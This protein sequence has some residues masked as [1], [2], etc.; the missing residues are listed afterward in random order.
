MRNENVKSSVSE[1]LKL[2]AKS[3]V[4][5]NLATVAT[6]AIFSALMWRGD[7]PES[8]QSDLVLASVFAGGIT[9]GLV[10]CK[11][12]RRGLAIAV[13]GAGAYFLSL[14]IIGIFRVQGDSLELDLVKYLI[15]AIT[16]GMFAAALRG[17]RKSKRKVKK[18]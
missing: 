13:L 10:A 18:R 3:A 5:G 9:A 11:K 14:V 17:A 2:T 4:L 1:F 6:L 15:C 12:E 7:L 8:M 16:G